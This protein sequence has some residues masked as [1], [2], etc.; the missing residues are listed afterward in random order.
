MDC[1]FLIWS[2]ESSRLG[3]KWK[4]GIPIEVIPMSYK[5]VQEKIETKYGGEA[6]LRM[7]ADKAV[8][9]KKKS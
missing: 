6:V 1:L 9:Q 2:K 8:G 5:P 4:K 3:L 7:S